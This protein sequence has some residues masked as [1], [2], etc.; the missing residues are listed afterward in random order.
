MSKTFG[1][2][3]E[4]GETREYLIISFS[5]SVLSIQ[6]RWR[7]NSLS[8][9]FLANYWGTFFPAHP[10]ESTHH[11]RTEV[12]DSV[13][14]IAN[15]LLENAIKFSYE[16][17]KIPIKIGIYLSTH[18]LRFYVS[19]SIDPQTIEPFHRYIQELLTEDPGELY[20]RQLE[21]NAQEENSTESRLGFLTLLNDYEAKL[22]WKFDTIQQESGESL[23]VTTMVELEIIRAQQA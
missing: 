10:S 3:V 8:A 1:N 7:N 23:V 19:N 2:Y 12:Q 5:S 21:R 20:I 6:D 18:L 9:D 14:Y 22:G 13:S 4:M 16:P 17:A 15:E 11:H